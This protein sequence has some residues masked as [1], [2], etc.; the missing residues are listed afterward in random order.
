MVALI[1]PMIIAVE[2][3]SASLLRYRIPAVRSIRTLQ[4]VLAHPVTCNLL[5]TPV[6]RKACGH[7]EHNTRSFQMLERED[8]N[9]GLE[10]KEIQG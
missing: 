10:G 1:P 7:S 5:E 8:K 4:G 6:A 2:H 9:Q 3:A